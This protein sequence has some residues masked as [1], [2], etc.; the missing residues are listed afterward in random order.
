[1]LFRSRQVELG[2][3]DS[4]LFEIR[5]NL[6]LGDLLIV[7][8]Q[9]EAVEGQPVDVRATVRDLK[10]L[11]RILLRAH[12]Q[13]AAAEDPADASTSAVPQAEPRPEYQ[14]DGGAGSAAGQAA[15]LATGQ[16][17]ADAR[18]NDQ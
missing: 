6:K 10:E 18:E 13:I 5:T 16:G 7:Q 11:P 12:Q 4:G 1:M 17:V 9:R 2:V 8:G 3:M 14:P 15:P